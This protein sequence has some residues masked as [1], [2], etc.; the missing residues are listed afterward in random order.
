MAVPE[1]SDKAMEYYRSGNVLWIV[2]Q[3]VALA[4]PCLVLFTGLSARMRTLARRIGRRWF[5]IVLVYFVFYSLLEY[6]LD[7]PLAYYAGYVRQHAYGLSNQ[8]FEKW[9][10]DSLKEL[11]VGMVFGVP[12]GVAAVPADPPQSAP[13]V[14]L[15][16]AA[17]ASRDVLRD[18]GRADLG[19]PAVQSLRPDEGQAV[20]GPDPGAGRAR[21]GSRAAASSRWIRAW[22]PRR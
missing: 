11:A 8:T 1:P 12:A 21:R 14:A 13:L 9:L 17:V 22:T 3:V 7:F 18:A 19:R 4:I 2:S 15:Y 5:F 6:A 20:G 10:A 16:G